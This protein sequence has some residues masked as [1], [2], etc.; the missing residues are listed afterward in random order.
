MGLEVLGRVGRDD[1]DRIATTDAACGQRGREASASF[2][3]LGPGPAHRAMHHGKTLGEDR[4]AALEEAER[5][6]GDVVCEFRTLG[7]D[8]QRILKARMRY[9]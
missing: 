8:M 9:P 6:Q 1:C 4:R 2:I 5:G 3:G 7:S